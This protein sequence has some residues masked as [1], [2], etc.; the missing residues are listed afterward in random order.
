MFR[1]VAT[2]L[3]LSGTEYLSAELRY[4]LLVRLLAMLGAYSIELLA[5]E[6]SRNTWSRG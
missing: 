5:P 1:L 2:T 4:M 6:R 3:Y